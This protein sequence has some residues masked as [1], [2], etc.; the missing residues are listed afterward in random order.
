MPRG[1]SPK[2]PDDDG[3]IGYVLSD[4]A[5]LI[6][7]VFDRRVRDIG[8]TRAQWLVMTRLYRRPGASQTELADMLETDRASAGRM[9]DRMEKSGWLERRPDGVDRRVNRLFL[10]AEA[11]RLHVRMWAIA[12]ATI[13]DALSPL[14]ALER[15][16][17]TDMAARVKGR[18]QLLA[19]G[20]PA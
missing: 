16:R 20:R 14:S 13:D 4:V 10:T 7:T 6:R 12:E 8:M 19:A 11:R 18:L 1:D 17:F 3:Y 15:E 9:I 2:G 5:R